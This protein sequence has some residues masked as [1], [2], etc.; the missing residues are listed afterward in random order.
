M[1]MIF[2]SDNFQAW[3]GFSSKVTCTFIQ[4]EKT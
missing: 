3:P 1:F 2:K 4:Q